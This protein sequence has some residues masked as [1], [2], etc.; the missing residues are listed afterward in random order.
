MDVQISAHPKCNTTIR[1]SSLYLFTYSI[2]PH[3]L[4]IRHKWCWLAVF[5]STWTNECFSNGSAEECL[6]I[7][8]DII[9]VDIYAFS[10]S[11][12]SDMWAM[13]LESQ[14]SR[15]LSKLKGVC[16]AL[17]SGRSFASKM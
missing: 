3:I 16:G 8:I 5:L 6:V 15:T 9:V 13:S 11:R 4:I 12:G 17:T 10:A 1:Y 7:E 2:T 14:H